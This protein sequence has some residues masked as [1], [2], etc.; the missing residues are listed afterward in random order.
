[1]LNSVRNCQL[2]FPKLI[3]LFYHPTSNE[4]DFSYF[5][6]S[7]MLNFLICKKNFLQ[8]NDWMSY[9]TLS[10]Q[11]FLM[12]GSHLVIGNLCTFFC[13][14]SKSLPIKNIEA[15][16]YFYWATRTLYIF[17]GFILFCFVSDICI[18]NFLYNLWLVF[19]LT[20]SLKMQI[21]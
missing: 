8:S 12:F 21:F 19:T 5:I 10:C 7:P 16:S 2:L 4:W 6:L 17:K 11:T 1:M 20:I 18:A 13:K 15:L 9:I 14:L 3:I